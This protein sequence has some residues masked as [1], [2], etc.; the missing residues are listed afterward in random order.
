MKYF[1][2]I[3]SALLFFTS[4]E[5][6]A[7]DITPADRL[8]DAIVFGDSTTAN[9]FLNDIYNNLNPGPW[10]SHF[11][12][13]PTEL[14]SDPL[15]DISDNAMYGPTGVPSSTYFDNSSYGPSANM[16]MPQWANMY[17]Y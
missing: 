15:D 16:F 7:L 14:C 8:S 12:A 9:L 13:L 3:L 5:K 10:S 4:C 17:N 11:S 1:A 2:V 6:D